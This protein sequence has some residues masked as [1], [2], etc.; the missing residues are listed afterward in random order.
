MGLVYVPA[1]IDP[2]FSSEGIRQSGITFEIHYT[3]LTGFRKSQILSGNVHDDRKPFPA[4]C[5][6]KHLKAWTLGKQVFT[7]G[8]VGLDN[9]TFQTTLSTD[10][11]PL[12]ELMGL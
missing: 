11:V 12:L 2:R 5:V 4:L 3:D 8:F 10:N 6:A 9:A 1:W 7:G